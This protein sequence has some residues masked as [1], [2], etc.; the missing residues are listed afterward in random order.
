MFDVKINNRKKIYVGNFSK[1]ISEVLV[2]AI[3]GHEVSSY[4]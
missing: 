4:V 2:I 1:K 3:L